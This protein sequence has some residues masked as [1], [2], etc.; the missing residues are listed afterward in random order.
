MLQTKS[1]NRTG[2]KKVKFIK[3]TAFNQ[4]QIITVEYKNAF[5]Q[6]GVKIIVYFMF[7]VKT[8]K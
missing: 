5:W 2:S 8:F 4:L 3:Q 6:Q 7:R 1:P